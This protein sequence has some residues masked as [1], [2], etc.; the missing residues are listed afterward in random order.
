M[1]RF[2]AGATTSSLLFVGLVVGS[3]FGDKDLNNV[4]Q[5][6]QNSPC[7]PCYLKRIARLPHRLDGKSGPQS[8]YTALV[9]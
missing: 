9:L 2:K 8:A 3:F 1:L 5:A 7:A 6:G 4:A